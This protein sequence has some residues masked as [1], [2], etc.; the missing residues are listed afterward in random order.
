MEFDQWI[1]VI[2]VAAPLIGSGFLG[3]FAKYYLDKKQE[4]M[5]KNAEFKRTAY[6]E[7]IDL[8]LTVM[9]SD[10]LGKQLPQKELI[11]RLNS[12]Y[13]QCILYASPEVI[14]AFGD[15]MQHMFKN[16]GENGDPKI[17]MIKITSIFKFMREDIG[18][19]NKLLGD[20]DEKLM[21]VRLNDYD[22]TME[23]SDN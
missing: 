5:S 6:S 14:N 4:Y 22:K 8:L 17:T 16:E 2:T 23:T 11:R 12:A 9:S 15:A 18:L 1:Q 7:V 19:S 21:R 3:Y 13:G 20:N 10:Q